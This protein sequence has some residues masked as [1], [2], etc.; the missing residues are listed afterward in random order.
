MEMLAIAAAY[1]VYD[2]N[3]NIQRPTL[4]LPTI[5]LN[6]NSRWLA[7]VGVLLFSG[8]LLVNIGQVANASNVL[9]TKIT[10]VTVATDVDCLNVRKAPDGDVVEC[11]DKGEALPDIVRKD[12]DWYQLTNSYWVHQDYVDGDGKELEELAEIEPDEVLRY[13]KDDVMQ[14]EAIATLQKHLNYYKLLDKP[15]TVDAVFGKE[16]H[17]AVL[18]FQRKRGLEMDGIVGTETR[19]ALDL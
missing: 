14:G 19:A 1:E 2:L 18:A 3:Q 12:G 5:Q 16:T 6:L 8:Q 10:K 11:V 15:I 9:T 17:V 13:V 4:E 7:Y